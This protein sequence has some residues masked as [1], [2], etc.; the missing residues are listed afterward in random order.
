M[1]YRHSV[2]HLLTQEPLATLVGRVRVPGEVGARIVAV[3]GSR[4]FDLTGLEATMSGLLE[5]PDLLY[6]VRTAS[7]DVSWPV[8][9]VVRDT[10]AGRGT[11][12]RLISPID[13]QIIKAAGVTFVKSMIERVIE[14]RA[15]GDATQAL[16]IRD[17]ITATVG[18]AIGSIRPG[19]DE[20]QEAKRILIAEGLWS[21]Y[22][23]VG[24]GPDPEIFTKA[25]VLSSVGT[26]TPIGVLERSTWNNPE[27][28]VVLA[29]TSGGR[30]VGA[31][32]GNDVNLRDFEGRS[33]LL[34]GEA[35]DNNGSCALGPMIRLF[36]ETFTGVENLDL[37]LRVTG[38]DGFQLDDGSSMSEMSRTIP[39]LIRYTVGAHH[40][41]PDGFVLF[42]GTLFAPTLD[43]DSEGL[44]F[45]HKDGDIVRI[46]CPE[47]GTLVNQ[48][49]S[50]ETCPPWTVGINS[51][52][53][54]L[55]VRGLLS[56][57]GSVS[58]V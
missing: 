54:D 19:S 52:F 40:Q 53:A 15:G 25:P 45:T 14:E 6:I 16:A 20:A 4:M 57:R 1:D 32:L 50:A 3:R 39:E 26:A 55:A 7:A 33:A 29:V 31:M 42:T 22:L 51:F 46:S 48:V 13:L 12:P 30:P 37:T 18:G 28:E 11:A 34:L 21:Q 5:R 8:A 58:S 38:E 24:I 36:D 43:R 44:G 17:R 49:R 56:S 35:K 23:E 27:P 9:D 47:L 2:D 10:L 41:Y